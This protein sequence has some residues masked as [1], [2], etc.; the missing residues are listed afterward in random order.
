MA[1]SF[2]I[3]GMIKAGGPTL[4]I[5]VIFF[6]V[7]VI[8]MVERWMYYRSIEISGKTAL[9]DIL[10]QL[11][12]GNYLEAIRSVSY[13]GPTGYVLSECISLLASSE[14]NRNS[15]LF[16]EVKTRAIAEKIPELEKYLS[17]LA[18]FAVISPFIG[19]LGTV[20]GIIRAFLA[21]GETTMAGLHSG[22]A[23]ALVATAAG[24]IVAIPSTAAYNLYRKR[25]E[26]ILLF[27]EVAASR[28]KQVYLTDR[29]NSGA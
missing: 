3:G 29:E 8:V 16:E 12:E 10:G 5:L 20:F 13:G 18:T 4:V 15:E 28:I 23:E 2:S 24:L 14:K 22:I 25:M 1:E 27:L 19:L 11:K 9:D 21:M 26:S 7:A 17:L 6:I